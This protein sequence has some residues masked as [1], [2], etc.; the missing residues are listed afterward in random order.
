MSSLTRLAPIV[1]GLGG[2]L[3]TVKAVVITVNDGSFDPVEGGVFIGGL[4]AL[5]VASIVVALTLTASRRGL[6][7]AAMTAGA[8][9]AL[10]AGTLLLTSVGQALVGAVAP[11]DNLGLEEEG[12]ILLAGLA[13]LTYA[14][15]S[16][17]G[18]SRSSRPTFAHG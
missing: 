2:T 1:A 15:R 7:R 6:A 12:G 18:F 13:W 3:W 5:L 14:T 4:L 11:G 10:V 9:I 17:R 8:A 16:N